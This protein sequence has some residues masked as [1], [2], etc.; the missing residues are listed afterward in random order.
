M[1][2]E[3]KAADQYHLETILIGFLPHTIAA[4]LYDGA[5]S[6]SFIT[7]QIPEL[8]KLYPDIPALGS[9]YDPVN[10][11][12]DDRFYGPTSQ[13]KRLASVS[14]DALFQSGRRLLLDAF[15]AEGR[16]Y[17][18][19]NYLFTADTPGADPALGVFHSS[20]ISFGKF[21]F[22]ESKCFPMLTNRSMHSVWSI[23]VGKRDEPSRQDITFHD[24]RLDCVCKHSPP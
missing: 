13:Y 6:P 21:P 16:E 11:S 2:D 20:E 19:Y 3:A 24:V 8:L 4:N 15:I 17:P 9:P 12:K 7:K 23:C 18:A 14:G 5:A 10:V 22:F 1:S